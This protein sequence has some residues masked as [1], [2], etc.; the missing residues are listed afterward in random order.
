LSKLDMNDLQVIE[1]DTNTISDLFSGMTVSLFGAE[2]GTK[3]KIDVD[4]DLSAT[5]TAIQD[6]VDAYNKVR[7]LINQHSLRNADGTKSADAGALF[8]TSII[9]DLRTSLNAVIGGDT[10]G[11]DSD[12]S[13]LASIG[14]TFVDNNTVSDPKEKDTLQ[15]DSTTLDKALTD[16][17]DEIRR[18]FAFDLTSSDPNVVL[19]GFT[20][21]TTYSPT[22]YTLNVGTLGTLHKDSAAVT[23]QTALL[24]TADSFN[25]TTSG[26][27]TIN[28]ATVTYDVTTD[29]LQS[30]ATKINDAS[31]TAAT[32]VS[33]RVV[34]GPNNT[35][36]LSLN[37]TQAAI[38]LSGDT[39][40]L[41]AAMAVTANTDK[42]DFANID[43]VGSGSNDGTVTVSGRTIEVTSESGAEGLKLF[44]NGSGSQSG[45]S[46]DFTVGLAARLSAVL[47]KFVDTTSGSI[48]TESDNLD[49]Q[50]KLAQTR[51]D[52]IDKRLDVYRNS[53][54]QS[55]L[56]MET[57]VTT[58]N[59]LLDSLK[60]QF[61]AMTNSNGNS[62]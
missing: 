40:D 15:I 35:L 53:L 6:F 21:K 11:I 52:E 28:G 34:S 51:I 8:G 5:K 19:L 44:Y 39:G 45:I 13:G 2:P 59:N 49:S 46:L 14:V 26:S 17:P 58:M 60:S 37:S 57:A 41:L 18:L 33:A 4:R 29:T 1:R 47:D 32:G 38:S 43:G 22:G 27:F 31:T 16:N 56:A 25:A 36:L 42:L 20:G 9:S 61:N 10:K 30:L 7:E 24:N 50:D 3:I 48:K 54:T 12:F 62:N 55:F 23:S